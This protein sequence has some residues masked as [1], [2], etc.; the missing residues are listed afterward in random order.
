MKIENLRMYCRVV[1]EESI[2]KAAKAAYISQ[3]AVTKQIRNLETYYNVRLFRRDHGKLILT[4]PGKMLYHYAKE[5]IAL[6][7]N[8]YEN[9]QIQQNNM[10][11]TL[12]M[13]ASPTIGEYLLPS[14]IGK[15][16]DMYF[17]VKFSLTIG[18]TP[19]IINLL[20]DN[21][22]DI[23]L[24][25]STFPQK[26]LKQQQFL[27]D[28]LS[29]VVS[30]KHRWKD[31][32]EIDLE[33][34]V[35]EK[36]IWREPESGLRQLIESYLKRDTI[37]ER[38]D[39]TIELG[40]VQAIK[41]A[42]EAGLGISILPT[43]TIEKELKYGILHKLTIKQ[44]SMTRYFVIVQKQRRFKKEIIRQFEEFLLRMNE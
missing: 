14:L 36:M 4:D 41:S 8:A 32:E 6:E 27:K 12:R 31:R 24:V 30:S 18:N 17:D 34:I 23:A 42:V 1:E 20:D 9:I 40:S 28:E 15:F 11:Q 5:I 26:H 10:Q 39:E 35:E 38:M 19:H 2:T 3:P 25:E 16:K 7:S 21:K 13:G 43:L 44:F 37:W 33:E 29:I 22:V